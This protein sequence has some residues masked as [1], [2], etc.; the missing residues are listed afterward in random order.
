MMKFLLTF[1]LVVSAFISVQA[2]NEYAPVVEKE[3][4][5]KNFEFKRYGDGKIVSLRDLMKDKKLVMVTYFAPWCHTWQHQKPLTEKLY[6][7]YKDKGFGIVG[8]SN[9]GSL[10]DLKIN[11]GEKG[12]AFPVVVESEK[13]EDRDKTTHFAYRQKTGDTRKWGSPY[14]IF[15]EPDKLDKKGDVL[16]EKTYVV[17]GELIEEDVEKFIR[18]KLGLANE[19][20]KVTAAN[21]NSKV[22][23][24]KP[25]PALSLKKPE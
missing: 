13:S 17:N 22:E 7:K 15:L 23:V 14:H 18:E 19:E 10:D 8:V 1:V 6:E 21:A 12:E 16:T 5:Y 4:S 3:I 11:I 9:Y 25:A 2:Q 24:C 20:K